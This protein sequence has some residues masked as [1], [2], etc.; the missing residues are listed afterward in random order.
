MTP[1]GRTPSR[2]KNSTT[3]ARRKSAGFNEV[4]RAAMKER[5]AELRAERRPSSRTDGTGE[6]LA[7]IAGMPEPDR[8]L[9]Q[10]VHS[11]VTTVAPS[12][13]PRLW[14]GM[15]AYAREGKVLCF[16]Q[17][18]AKFKSRYSTFAFSDSAN[19]DN[20]ACWA[21]GFALKA[22]TP[23]TEAMLKALLTRAVR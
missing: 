19:L 20:G 9:G 7:R 17:D 5:A 4:E 15:P 12:L 22:W 2:K 8:T 10:R 1:K 23:D 18:A 14:Y 21:T 11:L 16:F 6:V 3:S 13:S